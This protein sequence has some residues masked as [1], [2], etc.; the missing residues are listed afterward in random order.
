MIFTEW[1]L[2]ATILYLEIRIGSRFF[3][4]LNMFQ[5]FRQA[6]EYG[7]PLSQSLSRRIIRRSIGFIEFGLVG[8][9]ITRSLISR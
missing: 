2:G 9:A 7:E 6:F 5:Q 4:V 1:W 8:A 3:P